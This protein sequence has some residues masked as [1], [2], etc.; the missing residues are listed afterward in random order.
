M[1]QKGKIVTLG[2]NVLSTP[3]GNFGARGEYVCANAQITQGVT[4]TPT[5]LEDCLTK[6]PNIAKIAAAVGVT[7]SKSLWSFPGMCGPAGISYPVDIYLGTAS[8]ECLKI[9]SNP[10]LGPD[11]YGC[12]WGLPEAPFNCSCPELGSKFEAYLKLRLNVATF[13]NTPKDA[14]VKRKEFLDSIT[15]GRKVT[16]NISGD[17]SLRCGDLVEVLANNSSGYP[18]SAGTSPINGMYYVLGVKHMFT[19]TGTHETQLALTD[20]LSP[21]SGKT[22]TRSSPAT[23]SENPWDDTIN[24]PNKTGVF[25][26]PFD[27]SKNY[28]NWS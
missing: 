23:P 3:I 25:N 26:N 5:S 24:V 17:M 15:F 8:N 9:K 6:F 22:T 2:S 7:G 19:N 11:F 28:D 20:I 18:Y 16:I 14:P 27:S 13:W 10:N 1:P 4:A 12:L 21:T